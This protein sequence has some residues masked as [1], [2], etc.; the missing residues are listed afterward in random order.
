MIIVATFWAMFA[1]PLLVAVIIGS[2]T[3]PRVEKE[4]CLPFSTPNTVTAD[5]T[6]E[7]DRFSFEIRMTLPCIEGKIVSM[8][9]D[10][11]SLFAPNIN[12]LEFSAAIYATIPERRICMREWTSNNPNATFDTGPTPEGQAFWRLK[13]RQTQLFVSQPG[14]KPGRALAHAA[15]KLAQVWN[16]TVGVTP[17]KSSEAL[18]LA[19]GQAVDLI[20][21]H[22]KERGVNVSFLTS[23]DLSGWPVIQGDMRHGCCLAVRPLFTRGPA[24]YLVW[25]GD[26]QSNVTA[27]HELGHVLDWEERYHQMSH[28]ESVIFRNTWKDEAGANRQA[29]RWLRSCRREYAFQIGLHVFRRKDCL[30][31]MNAGIGAPK[32]LDIFRYLSEMLFVRNNH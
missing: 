25:R 14:R 4:V 7:W 21:L 6:F 17:P 15:D 27:L 19:A 16:M 28:S 23:K 13:A 20:V 2:I 10:G 32:R 31:S 12:W 22:L 11:A 18:E 30:D 8:G 29:L 9:W 24:A 3:M 5:P 26:S 1:L